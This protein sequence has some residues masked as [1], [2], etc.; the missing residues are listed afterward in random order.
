MQPLTDRRAAGR[1]LAEKLVG[2]AE[3]EDTIVLGL[4]RGG[5]VVAFEVAKALNAPLDIFLVRKLGA[6]GQEE[7]A[8]GAI[9]SGGIRVLNRDVVVALGL[10]ETEIEAVTKREQAE[11]ERREK[12][13]RG[14]SA[15]LD[16]EGK[17][18]I[19]VDD[20][21]ATGA[22]MRTA[23]RSLR[24]HRPARLVLAVPVAP[25]STCRALAEEADEAVCLMTPEP[26]Y[27]IGQWYEDFS[28]TS[29]DEVVGLLSESAAF[30]AGTSGRSQEGGQAR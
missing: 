27:S 19:V 29:D 4:P 13:Y 16:L 7:L 20:G 15:P 3:R 2:Y 11:L 25:A 22:S 9:A 8:V 30:G 24:A 5:V 28:Q 21:L 12:V 10:S 1:L 14:T 6:P 17:T 26:F 18:V 23:L